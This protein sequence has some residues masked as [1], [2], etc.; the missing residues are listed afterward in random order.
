[1]GIPSATTLRAIRQSL[2][3]HLSLMDNH[4]VPEPSLVDQGK[5]PMLFSKSGLESALKRYE[6]TSQKKEA[7]SA[8]RAALADSVEL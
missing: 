7:F 3:T 6:V 1:M 8:L 2:L 5:N 4:R